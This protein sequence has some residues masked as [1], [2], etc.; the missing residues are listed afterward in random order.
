MM[1]DSR[2]AKRAA[3]LK[4][5]ESET[6]V[7]L[8]SQMG[9]LPVGESNQHPL[10]AQWHG[11]TFMTARQGIRTACSGSGVCWHLP[12][13]AH[14]RKSVIEHPAWTTVLNKRHVKSTLLC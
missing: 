14:D 3:G 12:A 2:G 5:A 11:L 13:H 7:L 6:E 4:V 10:V 8:A 1:F 9:K